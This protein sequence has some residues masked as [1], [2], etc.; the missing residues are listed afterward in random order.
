MKIESAVYT[1]R[2]VNGKELVQSFLRKDGTPIY[3]KAIVGV[4]IGSTYEMT[5]ETHINRRP[6][7]LDVPVQRDAEWERKDLEAEMAQ[8]R[9]RL[10]A[11][12]KGDSRPAVD[13]AAA[14]LRPLIQGKGF[15]E[16][17]AIVEYLITL[18]E[19]P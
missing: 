13:R 9:W 7:L 10:E 17:K 6:K 18:A 16:K 2:R 5:D 12:L 8:K 11:K 3:F 19:K 15:W 4:S 14:A 1:G